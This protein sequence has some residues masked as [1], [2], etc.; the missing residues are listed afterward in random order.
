MK[1]P[2]LMVGALSWEEL[3][4]STVRTFLALCANKPSI[5][6]QTSETLVGSF[7]DAEMF[8]PKDHEL[9]SKIRRHS[10]RNWVKT[11]TP[12]LL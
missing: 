9:W 3:Y 1:V 5:P 2:C 6:R 8:W 10:G 4:I 11:V 12:M 7:I